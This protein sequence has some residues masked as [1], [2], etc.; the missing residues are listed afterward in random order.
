[1][2]NFIL[3][4]TKK[5]LGKYK[6]LIIPFTFSA[7]FILTSFVSFNFYF[8]DRI[9]PGINAGGISISGMTPQQAKQ[10]LEKEIV[11]PEKIT[12]FAKEEK[13]DL[14]LSDINFAYDYAST[15]E[16]A[17]KIYR[18]DNFFINQ[19]G[20]LFS[21]FKKQNI[22]IR[23][24]LDHQKLD[25]YLEI[26]S[27]QVSTEPKYP[28]VF[29]RDGQIDIDKGT[30][31]EKIDRENFKKLLINQLST[32]NY[33]PITIPFYSIDP[34]LNEK[35]VKDLKER[36]KKFLGK[37][38]KLTYEYTTINLSEKETLNFLD[39]RG[40]FDKE[41]ITR[42]LEET[43]SPKVNRNPQN[44]VFNFVDGKVQEFKPAKDGL[45]ID[46]PTLTKKIIEALS[47]LETSEE[48][49]LILAIP[50][51]ITPPAITTEE[52]NNLGIKELLGRG[53][54]SFRGSIPARVFNIGHAAKKL[55]G[56][57]IPPG[58]TL[59]FNTLVGEV[60]SLTGYKQAYIIKDGSTIL[61]DGGG[62]CQVSTTLFRAALDAG[63]PIEERHAH[64]YRVSYYE[65]GSPPGLDATVFAPTTDLKIKNDTPG[66][67]L[68]QTI[69]MPTE[70]TLVFEIY[71]TKDGRV[72]TITKPVISNSSA[73]PEDLYIDDPTLPA[74]QIKQI[75][76]KAWGAK[77]TFDYK[78][79]RNGEI[80]YQK[81]FLS[82]YRPWQAKFLRGVGPAN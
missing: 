31:G 48:K 62:V 65:Q 78:V 28:M 67:I 34:T 14:S 39:P 59:S 72:A 82:N 47:Q 57:L 13:F 36:A 58:E 11:P 35:E 41:K 45:T 19:I 77:V 33:S 40:D 26:V 69:F 61:G 27:N 64:S 10:K 50:V 20:R 76:Y 7:I 75:D 29:L 22:T 1:M 68:I 24:F 52:V 66:Y 21:L 23:T 3:E 2:S 71:G 9:F 70:S 63:L 51:K 54:S 80:I 53:V 25:E 37:N 74:G 73:P 43:I 49:E 5:L 32:Q 16:T 18:E 55:N 12:L 44:A 56:A 81:T 4:I 42:F 38:I 46:V 60:S 30:P 79:E 6:E 15:S 17:F 8:R